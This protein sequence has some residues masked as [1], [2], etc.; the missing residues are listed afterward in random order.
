MGK[1]MF[2]GLPIK[3]L[4]RFHFDSIEKVGQVNCPVV[5]THSVDDEIVPFEMGKRLFEAAGEP[6][7]FIELTGG[8]NER[9]YFAQKSYNETIRWLMHG[10]GG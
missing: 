7:R 10:D 5:V 8:H 3:Y 4:L 2:P 9:F 1:R 6:K